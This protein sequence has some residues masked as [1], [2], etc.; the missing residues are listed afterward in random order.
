METGSAKTLKVA[1]EL[2]EGEHSTK[3]VW[4]FNV[5]SVQQYSRDVVEAEIIS[6]FPHIQAKGL[7]LNLFHFDEI[8]GKVKIESD[9]DMQEALTNFM[10]E[11]HGTRRHQF[12]VLHAEDMCPVSVAVTHPDE[13]AQLNPASKS[14]KVCL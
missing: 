11:W 7:R 10:E 2:H 14:R 6:L 1:I 9:G 5:D 3:K 13:S 12:L 4:R 8:A